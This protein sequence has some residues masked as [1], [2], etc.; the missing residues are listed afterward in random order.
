MVP[1]AP[2]AG[3]APPKPTHSMTCGP[4]AYTAH[5]VGTVAR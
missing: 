3:M 5:G 1:E 4:T 2:T